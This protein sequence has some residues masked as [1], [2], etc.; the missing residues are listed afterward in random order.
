RG[1][2]V[3]ADMTDHR[4]PFAFLEAEADRF[5]QLVFADALRH[6]AEGQ[7]AGGFGAGGRGDLDARV[8]TTHRILAELLQGIAPGAYGCAVDRGY[9]VAG[10]YSSLGR[11]PG[12]GVD[13]GQVI[14]LAD[15]EHQPEGGDG[16]QEVEGGT[17]CGDRHAL[18]DR[19]AVMGLVEF[20]GRHLRLALVEHLDVAAE[21]DCGNREFG[22][23][24]ITP[25]PQRLA[26]A[27]RKT[28]HLHPAITGDDEMPELVEGHQQSEG[29]DEPPDGSKKLVH[30]NVPIALLGWERCRPGAWGPGSRDGDSARHGRNDTLCF[31]TR[32]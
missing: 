3:G 4:R 31:A 1:R 20:F 29:D 26:E 30:Q 2:H 17:G 23:M 18:T 13:D 7:R 32:G 28:Q 25:R 24:A 15:H 10:K 22:A 8:V 5:E 9:T 6:R 14:R 21:R 27:D 16:E 11:D 12:R 19:L